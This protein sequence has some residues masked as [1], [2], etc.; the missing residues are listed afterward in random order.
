VETVPEALKWQHRV[1]V[2]EK[3]GRTALVFPAVFLIIK[4]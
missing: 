1:T 4:E 3:S 2:M